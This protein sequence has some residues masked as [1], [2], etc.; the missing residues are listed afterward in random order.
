MLSLMVSYV[1]SAA[2][3]W[4]AW[5]LA[6]SLDAA[7]LLALAGLVWIAIR[8]RVAPQVGCWLFLLV[9]LKLLL[10]VVVTVPTA[11]ARWTPSA[12][13]SSWYLGTRI[14]ETAESRPPV[15]TRIATAGSGPAGRPETRLEPV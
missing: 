3:R 5:V 4:A 11:V 2:D 10:P 15:E 1:N 7:G 12:L 9:P 8:R 14:P 13:V 6:A